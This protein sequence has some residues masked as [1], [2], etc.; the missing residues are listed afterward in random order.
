MVTLHDGLDAPFP[1]ETLGRL[2]AHFC[3]AAC[4]V[5]SSVVQEQ[6]QGIRCWR[7]PLLV[8]AG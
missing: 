4:Q 6:L 5:V 8:N 2:L 7:S 3:A 1:F